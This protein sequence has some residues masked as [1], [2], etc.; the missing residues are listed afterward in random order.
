MGDPLYGLFL[1][2]QALTRLGGV[3]DLGI[4][5]ALSLR[6]SAMM[7]RK[8][9]AE[10]RELL[11]SARTLFLL[12]ATG[13]CVVFVA[14]SPWLPKWLGFAD[15][16]LA[17]SMTWLFIYGG[18]SLAMMIVS[19]YFA[20]LNYA[21]CTVTWPIFPTLFAA[22]FV[23]P[24]LHW[25]LALLH[26]PLWIQLLPYLGSSTAMAFVGWRMLKWSHP[27]LGNLR[28]LRKNFA[29]WKSLAG[30]SWW[31]YLIGLGTAIYFTT[32]RLVIGAAMGTAVIPKYQANY[33]AC[34]LL[35]SVIVTGAFV[36][37]PKMNQ[38]ISSSDPAD[39]Q[40]LLVEVNRLSIFEVVLG[41][42]A[43]L[44]YIAFNNLFVRLW[45]DEV[46][47]APLIWQFAFAANLAVT[48]GGNAGIQLSTRAGDK[49][50]RLAGLAAVS[51]G[52]L[53]LAL[54]ILSVKLGSITGVAVA[55][56]IAQSLS[57]ICLGVVAC[58][59]LNLSVV[60]WTAR[61]WLLPISLTVA[62]AG[63]KELLP[64]DSVT[65]LSVLAGCYLVLFFAACRLAG[66][67]KDMLRAEIV[68][69]RRMVG[70]S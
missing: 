29:Q 14:L 58:R 65:H 40:R 61:C 12:V 1:N 4:T 19:G 68:Q 46:H 20:C 39:R 15:V 50:L 7:G 22:Q 57:S 24:F 53:N 51:T 35:I 5:G 44:G 62:A 26:L 48:V 47:Q 30:A 36:V 6:S 3:G 41:C 10:L 56:V 42:G 43:V 25:C 28:P 60:R 31:V 69:L 45:L 27:W 55:T 2:F 23:S 52:L 49:G 70:L 37:L 8:D 16:P 67:T 34:E 17:G 38:W 18:L 66:F 63:L 13:L 59:Y 21:H 54:S 33:K 9:E 64:R 11:A 32:D